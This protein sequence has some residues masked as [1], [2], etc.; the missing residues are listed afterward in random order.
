MHGVEELL[1]LRL[2]LSGV[3]RGERARDAM[4]HVVVENPEREALERGVDRRD[5]REHVDAVPILLDHA[6]DAP[7]L[8]L[9]AMQTADQRVLVGRVAP[10]LRRLR[11]AHAV[12]PSRVER[13][14]R[15]RSEFVTTKRLEN[16]IAAAATIGLRRPATASGMAATL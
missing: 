10:H 11:V 8:T 15:R 16:A 14:R 6:L 3:A 7:D 5:L 4:V 12:T 13:N 1:A 9:D 2:R